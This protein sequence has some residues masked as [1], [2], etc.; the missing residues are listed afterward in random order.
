M[1]PIDFLFG[2]FFFLGGA[3]EQALDLLTDA[4]TKDLD[5][6][7]E[8]YSHVIRALH[9]PAPTLAAQLL[10]E[11]GNW[12]PAPQNARFH[13]TPMLKWQRE[14]KQYGCGVRNK[15]DWQGQGPVPKPKVNG[16]WCLS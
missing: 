4:W 2:V 6:S 12:G 8:C 5:P 7:V 15:I 16:C 9:R 11:L 14:M 13:T 1:D 3:W 10:K